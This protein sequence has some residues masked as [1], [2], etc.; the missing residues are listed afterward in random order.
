MIDDLPRPEDKGTKHANVRHKCLVPSGQPTWVLPGV[1]RSGPH[2]WASSTWSS[3][4]AGPSKLQLAQAAGQ[5][6]AQLK[7]PLF[8]LGIMPMWEDDA[9]ANGGKSPAG[10]APCWLP[11]SLRPDWSRPLPSPASEG[12][13]LTRLAANLALSSG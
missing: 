1:L 2:D 9:N 8:K 10:E 4:I 3:H 12:S 5:A 13:P 6:G 7:L 11:F